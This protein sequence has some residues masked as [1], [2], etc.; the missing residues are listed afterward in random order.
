MLAR[1]DTG[2]SCKFS[3]GSTQMSRKMVWKREKQLIRQ[4]WNNCPAQS[5][6]NQVITTEGLKIR[7]KNKSV[8]AM[9]KA[10]V[11]YEDLHSSCLTYRK[12][13]ELSSS[14]L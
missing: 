5:Y 11:P 9:I 1:C 6:E 8:N 12:P 7:G 13:E 2:T 3:P 4:Q 14:R 10:I